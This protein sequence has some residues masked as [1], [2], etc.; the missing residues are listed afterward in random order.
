MNASGPAL[1]RILKMAVST[2]SA[3]FA[4]NVALIGSSISWSLRDDFETSSKRILFV[5]RSA[6]DQ[7]T[8]FMPSMRLTKGQTVQFPTNTNNDLSVAGR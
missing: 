6:W 4:G 7:T 2:T 1:S 5:L 3:A 8:F